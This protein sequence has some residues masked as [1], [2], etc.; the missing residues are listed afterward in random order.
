LL[1][2]TQQVGSDLVITLDPTD[3]L[4]LKNTSLAAFQSSDVHFV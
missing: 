2:A 3:S 4:T 1:G